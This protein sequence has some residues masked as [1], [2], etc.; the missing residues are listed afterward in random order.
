VRRDAPHA[1]NSVRRKEKKAA[2][3][4]AAAAGGSWEEREG[5]KGTKTRTARAEW[6]KRTR[7]RMQRGLQTL[8]CEESGGTFPPLLSVT[9]FSPFLGAR[10]AALFMT[11]S[12]SLA[13]VFLRHYTWKNSLP[14]KL[15]IEP[16]VHAAS[17]RIAGHTV[18]SMS[19]VL[20]M[21]Q[22]ANIE[23]GREQIE[24]SRN[25]R[26]R[27]P[28]RLMAEIYLKSITKNKY[29]IRMQV[30]FDIRTLQRYADFQRAT[31]ANAI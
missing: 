6:Q 9:H 16:R 11:L 17:W 14:W 25:E 7:G 19:V 2:A 18:S 21:M 15:D 10:S 29:V 28:V 23:F 13:A 30:P 8:P 22:H 31:A 26:L 12:T 24:E 20:R 27:G 5:K 4:A 1:D 3:A